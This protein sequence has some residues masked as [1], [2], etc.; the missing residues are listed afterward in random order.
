MMLY[1]QNTL[2][3][4]LSENTSISHQNINLCHYPLWRKVCLRE[5]A[6]QEVMCNTDKK[7]EMQ[8]GCWEATVD[9]EG[10]DDLE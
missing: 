9:S 2:F 4:S 3:F 8:I 1:P 7:G 5:A 6:L 10:G